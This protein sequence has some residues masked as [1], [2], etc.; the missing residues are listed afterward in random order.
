MSIVFGAFV[1]EQRSHL[2]L[3]VDQ[4][5]RQM[6]HFLIIITTHFDGVSLIDILDKLVVLTKDN[7]CLVEASIEPTK[8]IKP[9]NLLSISVQ[10]YVQSVSNICSFDNNCFESFFD[11][12][13]SLSLY[14]TIESDLDRVGGVNYLFHAY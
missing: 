4:L 7:V 9:I 3:L 12:Q 10:V 6:D 14:I 13:T 11:F 5:Q 2:L 1:G 8:D